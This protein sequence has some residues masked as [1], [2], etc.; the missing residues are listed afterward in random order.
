MVFEKIVW[1]FWLYRLPTATVIASRGIEMI[2]VDVSK[3][4]INT[5]N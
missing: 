2:G 1:W 5:I 3:R 4:V